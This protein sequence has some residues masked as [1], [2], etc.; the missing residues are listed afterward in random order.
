MPATNEKQPDQKRIVASLA[1]ECHLPT[2]EMATLYE[3][4]RTELASGAHTT[5]YQSWMR[6]GNT[7][8]SDL[9]PAC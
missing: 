9:R 8:S 3:H 2:G 5:K 1:S 4:E 7:K 6:L